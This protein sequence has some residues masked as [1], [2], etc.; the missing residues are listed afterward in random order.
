MP[1]KAQTMNLNNIA[2]ALLLILGLAV[3]VACLRV[4]GF[5]FRAFLDSSPVDLLGSY[6][7]LGLVSLRIV[8]L[9]AFQDGAVLSFAFEI[10]VLWSA[11]AA[12]LAGLTQLQ[13]RAAKTTSGNRSRTSEPVQGDN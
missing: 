13:S 8:Q 12:I 7:G 9:I 4:M 2:G 5:Q 1:G 10:L 3:M 11:I 6:I